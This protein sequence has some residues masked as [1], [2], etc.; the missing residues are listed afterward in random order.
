MKL[1][2]LAI[3]L[4]GTIILMNIAGIETNSGKF[5][6]Y[7]FSDG[8][9]SL[10]TSEIWIYFS[11]IIIL[12]GAVGVKAGFFGGSPDPAFAIAPLAGIFGAVILSD[13]IGLYGKLNE[14]GQNVDG[15]LNWMGNIF[16]ISFALL[17]LAFVFS[18]VSW[19]RGSDG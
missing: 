16:L 10:R 12:A 14:Y 19:W 17:F 18:L 8:I 3:I 11:A 13:L 15:T 4:A 9:S 2:T 6:T 7:V 1:L 5:I